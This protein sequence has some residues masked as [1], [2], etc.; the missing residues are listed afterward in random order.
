MGRMSM[1][2]CLT[3]Y[4]KWTTIMVKQIK[5]ILMKSV[6]VQARIS[7]SLKKKADTIFKRI[8]LTPSQVIN[9][10]YAQ[11]VLRKGLPFELRIP[12]NTTLD[13]INELE[14][15]DGNTYSSFKEMIDDL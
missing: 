2:L 8:G 4:Y 6:T 5:G 10:M 11:V 12:N 7:P 9:A 14:R 1:P 13:A 3:M 15:G